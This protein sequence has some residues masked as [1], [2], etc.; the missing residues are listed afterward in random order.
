MTERICQQA[1]DRDGSV[2]ANRAL[3]VLERAVVFALPQGGGAA[4]REDQ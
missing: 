2:E 1:G 4:I 3:G